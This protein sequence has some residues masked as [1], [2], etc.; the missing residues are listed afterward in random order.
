MNT[1]YSISKAL[2][3]CL[4]ATVVVASYCGAVQADS[5]SGQS[6]PARSI[7][8]SWRNMV[9]FTNCSTGMELR[10]PF[11]ALNSFFMDGNLIENGSGISP[12]LRSISHGTWRRVGKRSF[13]ARSE[14]QLFDASGAFI[15]VQVN[16]REFN[17]AEDGASLISSARVIR[18][19][20]DG[21]LLTTF[22]ATET[23]ERLPEPVWP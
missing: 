10:S 11:P 19:G 2:A 13:I 4:T 8:G 21:S 22:C 6:R 7:V 3:T 12:A 20:I 5:P 15:G 18:T 9:T 17:V 16:T 14:I 1:L 23:G